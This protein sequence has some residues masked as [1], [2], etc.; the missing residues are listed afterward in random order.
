MELIKKEKTIPSIEE[1]P[2]LFIGTGEVRGFQFTQV[3]K[4]ESAYIYQV[5][6]EGKIYFEIFER[7]ST[8]KCID[9]KQRIYSETEFKEIYPKANSFGFWAWTYPTY[10][11]ALQKFDEISSRIAR[12]FERSN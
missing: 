1:L 8:Q 9:F 5:N 10:Q 3:K 12:N 4:S 11:Q 2:K 7:K 6:V